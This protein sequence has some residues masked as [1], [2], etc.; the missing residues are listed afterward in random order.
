[1]KCLHPQ[2]NLT[3]SI[4]NDNY[5]LIRTTR[6]GTALEEGKCKELKTVSAGDSVTMTST[7]SLMSS[8]SGGN[9]ALGARVDS[10]TNTVKVGQGKLIKGW[11][12]GLVGACEGEARRIVVGPSLAWRREGVE[13]LVPG[14]SSVVIDVQVDKVE[15]DLVFNFLNQIS[16]GT[17]G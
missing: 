4:I 6:E 5:Y 8:S 13:G 1:M 11:E 7:V 12:T 9:R 14:N 2:L 10:S 16:S 15:R 3:L 17:F